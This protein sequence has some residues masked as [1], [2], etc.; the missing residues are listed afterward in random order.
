IRQLTQNQLLLLAKNFPSQLLFRWAAR[1]AWAHMLWAA[2]A[3]RKKRLRAYLAGI[4][5]FMRL[6]PHAFRERKTWSREE[7][8]E[9]KARL[10]ASEGAIHTDV[11]SP[12]RL[13]KDTF[14]KLYFALFPA[15]HLQP[16]DVKPGLNRPP[17]P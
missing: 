4:G 12:D 15:P 17:V 1:I 5:G 14:W 16:S 6:L 3:V 8:A 9:F 10:E 2:M 13:E 11:S 7:V